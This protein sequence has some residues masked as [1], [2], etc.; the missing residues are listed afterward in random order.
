[1]DS[2][3]DSTSATTGSIQTDGGVGI[4]KALFVGT[5]VTVNGGT[6][7]GVTY[8]NASKVLTSGSALTFDG[9]NLGLGIATPTANQG[10]A[11]HIN[12]ATQSALRL[13]NSTS[14]TASTNGVNI[15]LFTNDFYINNQ[16][17]P[18]IFFNSGSEQMRLTSTGLGIGTS[19][20]GARLNLVDGSGDVMLTGSI[21][22]WNRNPNTGA[23]PDAAKG[24]AMIN[25]GT[26]GGGSLQFWTSSGVNGSGF[27][28]RLTLDSSGNL[29]LG[30]TPS[31]ANRATFQSAFGIYS[32]QIESHFIANGYFDSGW[33]Y[34]GTGYAPLYFSGAADGQHKWFITPSGTA[35]NAIS[36]TQAMTLDAS[37]N[38]GIG[39][40]SPTF[41]ISVK[42]A[43]S[44][45]SG[46]NFKNTVQNQELQIGC[47]AASTD[48]FF[49][50]PTNTAI[51]FGTNDI[52]RARITSGGDL[53]VGT[54][55]SW[56][57]PGA[58]TAKIFN[59]D[60]YAVG[61]STTNANLTNDRLVFNGGQ[62]YVLNE[63]STGVILTSG[64][65]AWAAQSDER[66]KNIIEPI[67]EAVKKVATLRAVIG[68][69]KT[70]SNEIRRAFLI[71]Q[72]VQK[73]LPEAVSAADDEAGTL[74]L[75]YSE[76]IPLLT[77]AIQ[78]QQ[79]LITALTARITA[80]ESSTLQ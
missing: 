22:S 34:V 55:T 3:T 52:E 60:G 25:A 38:L 42:G 16:G 39:E 18:T 69:Y 23:I 68:K 50:T 17:G 54:T 7:N 27:A 12:D 36:F 53:L 65:T 66:T 76:I 78:E 20:P 29:G 31:A 72:D 62:Y 11:L 14:G 37:G 57:P 75:R 4:A 74:S 45:T 41:R 6:A 48:S 40:T 8:L 44:V 56:T 49:N 59:N 46:I 35:G 70:D 5:T 64:Q 79:T 28:N 26:T 67:S 9:T 80:L 1:V 43:T 47:S 77:A 32:G 51:Y 19:S 10:N 73:V 58:T 24:T 33:K 2:T 71:A 15:A 21:I 13:T 63:S 61:N 30:V